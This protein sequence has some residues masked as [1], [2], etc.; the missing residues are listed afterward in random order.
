MERLSCRELLL[1]EFRRRL[2]S[3]GRSSLRYE[4]VEVLPEGEKALTRRFRKHVAVA[5]SHGWSFDQEMVRKYPE[6]VTGWPTEY[7]T[8]SF[9]GE[10]NNH[11]SRVA[12]VVHLYYLELWPELEF[13]LRQ[14]N[15]N[16][17]LVVTLTVSDRNTINR[18]RVFC[19]TATIVIVENKGRDIRPFLLLLEDGHLDKFDL[20]CK[21]H[22]KRALGG[23]R[24]P[25]FGDVWRRATFLDLIC[26]R[27][28][29]ESIIAQFEADPKLGIVGPAR[30]RSIST[31][32]EPRDVLGPNR[33][34]VESLAAEM[35]GG[36]LGP[37]FDFFE[38]TMFWIRPAALAP[39]RKLRLAQ[40]GF[41]GEEG[42]NDGAIEHAIE[43]LFN[44]VVRIAG[45]RVDETKAP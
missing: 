34:R 32:A 43:R 45:Y 13:V 44:H 41:E 39:L 6:I 42:H 40:S 3:F 26:G 15:L 16:M 5:R 29:V 14:S 33:A 37:N 18:I 12:V 38:G 4:D 27:A 11:K 31:A 20:V 25:I 7:P 8:S 1:T 30:L 35:G 19:P 9:Q 17:E 22:G 23:G 2:T 28:N 21:L 24:L 36:E 10:E